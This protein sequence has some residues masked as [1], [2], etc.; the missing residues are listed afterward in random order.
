M[1]KINIYYIIHREYLIVKYSIMNFKGLKS[2]IQNLVSSYTCPDCWSNTKEE[3]ID[4]MWAAG[5]T[6]NIDIECSECGKHSL[7]KTEVLSLDASKISFWEKEIQLLRSLLQQNGVQKSWNDHK[8]KD[9]EIV[10]LDKELKKENLNI[11][12]LFSENNEW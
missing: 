7:L 2:M 9:E 5:T 1:K 6:I 8:M 12:D 11:S 4:I 3:N 10:N